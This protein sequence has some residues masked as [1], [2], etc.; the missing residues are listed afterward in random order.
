MCPGERPARDGRDVR[1][2]LRDEF[3]EDPFLP[4]S[5]DFASL[6]DCIMIVSASN[7]ITPILNSRN[8]GKEVRIICDVS[9]PSDVDSELIKARPDIEIIRGGIARAP[10]ANDFEV[11][12]LKLS[13]NCLLACM[14]ETAVLGLAGRCDF[15]STGEIAS[16][17]VRKCQILAE[18]LGFE[19]GY[20]AAEK[21]FSFELE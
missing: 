5:A 4:V 6:A 19:L 7:A 2:M 11:D 20:A 16:E 3:G 18:S 1:R 14:A 10:A 9:V 13:H 17:S 8:V 21:S 12:F 15:A